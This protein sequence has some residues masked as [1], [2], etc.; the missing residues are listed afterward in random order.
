MARIHLVSGAS[1]GIG[2]RIAEE[3]QRAGDEVVPVVRRAEDAA[4]LGATRHLLCDFADPA[5]TQSAFQA[6]AGPVDSF[7]NAAGIAIGKAIWDTAPG[8][9]GNLMNVNLISPM[10]ACGALRGKINPGGAIILLS[11]QSAYRGGW[12]D[13][14]N[15]SKGGINTFIKSLAMKLA[16]DVRVIGIAP[17]IVIGTRMTAGRQQNDLERIKETIPLKRFAEVGEVAAMTLSLLGPAGANVTGA[18]IDMNG[19]NYLR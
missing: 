12:D 19:G 9:I 3:L 17:G 10:L 7:I 6:F 1:S 16:P 13:A 2:A 5:Q 18:V 8:D 11:S 15:A 14:Y 4:K